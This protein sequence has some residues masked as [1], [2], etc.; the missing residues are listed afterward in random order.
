VFL[1]LV[2]RCALFLSPLI[3]LPLK[4]LAGAGTLKEH[5]LAELKTPGSAK[6]QGAP[7]SQSERIEP[8]PTER[9]VRY[10]K[11]DCDSLY[12]CGVELIAGCYMR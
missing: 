5:N 1:N 4:R 12:R 9:E 10:H 11:C 2:P 3:H 8:L 6:D 7:S